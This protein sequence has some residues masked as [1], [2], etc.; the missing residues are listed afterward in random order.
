[1]SDHPRL[2]DLLPDEQRNLYIGG[3]WREAN[4]GER[5]VVLD[6]ADGSV[7]TDV[8]DGVGRTTR[9]TRWTPPR[10]PS[11]TGRGPRRGSVA[12][13]CAARSS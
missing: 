11:P 13:S 9:W 5:F 12:R 6:P 8:A 4:G 10:P 3:G 2:N 1:M 7:I